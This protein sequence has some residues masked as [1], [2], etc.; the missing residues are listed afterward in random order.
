MEPRGQFW[1]ILDQQKKFCGGASFDGNGLGFALGL[2]VLGQRDAQ[3][4]VGVSGV[5]PRNIHPGHIKAAGEATVAALAP[6]V[7]ALFVLVLKVTVTL[8]LDGQCVA[9]E[10]QRDVLFLEPGKGL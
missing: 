4:A 5:N 3:H 7:T 9:V 10:A 8:R 6:Q 2:D 1:L